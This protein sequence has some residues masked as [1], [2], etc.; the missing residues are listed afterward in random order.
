MWPDSSLHR[1]GFLFLSF[2]SSGFSFSVFITK[3]CIPH[4]FPSR[5]SKNSVTNSWPKPTIQFRLLM[6]TKVLKLQRI[7]QGI[8]AN[9]RRRD[10]DRVQRFAV[11]LLNIMFYTPILD[12]PDFTQMAMLN[13]MSSFPFIQPNPFMNPEMFN[14]LLAQQM[15]QMA[16]SPAKRAR[17]RISDDQLKI[18]RQYFD[19]NN[20]PSEAQI[21]EMSMKAGLPE[22]VIKHWFRNTLFKVSQDGF[23]VSV[24]K[25]TGPR[26]NQHNECH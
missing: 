24:L 13:M 23:F 9:R 16:Q 3:K 15:A 17:T 10:H 18:L 25:I 19:I 4:L 7:L 21:K 20:S 5:S 14:P 2:S 22:K 26:R 12:K 8:I 1:G 11:N 6:A